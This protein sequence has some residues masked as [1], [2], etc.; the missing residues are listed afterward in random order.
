MPAVAPTPPRPDADQRFRWTRA[1]YDQ[2]VETG[3][4]TSEDKI[5]LLDGEI[6]PK[7]TQNNPHRTSTLLTG[8][9]LRTAFGR[10]AFVQE[11][12]PVALSDQ[13]EP[14]PDIAV[15]RGAIRDYL[16]DHPGPDTIL[17]IVEVAGSSLLRDRIRKARL[18]AEAGIAEYW[19][20]NLV[21]HVLEVHREPV[22]A[23]YRT[24]TTYGPEDAVAP[25]HAPDAQLSV[26]DLLP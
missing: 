16:D 23:A 26:A 22:G 6:V 18:Y 20:V 2:A 17:L 3:V 11:E 5:E 7:M 9:A 19:I 1:R 10:E 24:K 21:D 4:F 14:E 15:I 25:L 8:A 13:S 12:K